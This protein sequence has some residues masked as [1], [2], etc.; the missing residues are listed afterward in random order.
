[1]EGLCNDTLYALL[2][3]EDYNEYSRAGLKARG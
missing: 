3:V 1:M 2:H